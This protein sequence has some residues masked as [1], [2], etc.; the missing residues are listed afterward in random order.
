MPMSTCRPSYRACSDPNDGWQPTSGLAGEKPVPQRRLQPH[1]RT[2]TSEGVHGALLSD[3]TNQKQARH[4]VIAR[5]LKA[6]EQG[7]A[8]PSRSAPLLESIAACEAAI[9]CH[10]SMPALASR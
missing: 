1:G 7:A 8:P 9:S 3:E 4:D 2:A 6:R 5:E 10:C